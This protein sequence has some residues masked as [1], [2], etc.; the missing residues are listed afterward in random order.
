MA[1]SIDRPK[2]KLR[3]FLRGAT[4]I[5]I[6]IPGVGRTEYPAAAKA[7]YNDGVALI[8][9]GDVDGAIEQF[10]L[11]IKTEPNFAEAR[12]A[13]GATLGRKGDT[14]GSI[15][16]LQEALRLRPS[17]AEAYYNL[18]VALLSK[19]DLDAAIRQF[20]IS[21]RIDMRQYKTH[22]N[23][24]NSTPATRRPRRGH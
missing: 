15:R 12:N 24:G 23:L 5:L 3:Q 4:L 11:A 1:R 13:L 14:E 2:L 20:R 17:Y 8:R 7:A 10:R 16:E 19:G 6:L 22:Y 18:G 9:R 21:L